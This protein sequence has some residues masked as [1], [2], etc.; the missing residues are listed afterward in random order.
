[1]WYKPGSFSFL[2]KE[3]KVNFYQDLYM[4]QQVFPDSLGKIVNSVVRLRKNN[5]YLISTNAIWSLNPTF[6]KEKCSCRFGASYLFPQRTDSEKLVKADGVLKSKVYKFQNT[7]HLQ[8]PHVPFPQVI[9]G[10]NVPAVIM[11]RISAWKHDFVTFKF[12]RTGHHTYTEN[13]VLANYFALLGFALG[14]LKQLLQFWHS[15]V[16][17]GFVLFWFLHSFWHMSSY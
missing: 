11:T 17:M 10:E 6:M 4:Y 8:Y 3:Q 5:E 2:A 1:M 14:K 7:P 16:G 13:L 12:Y 15:R 9:S